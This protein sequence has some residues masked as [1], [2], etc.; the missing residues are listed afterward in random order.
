MN[1][2][3]EIEKKFENVIAS[4]NDLKKQF[5][6]FNFDSHD[7]TKPW[8]R[9]FHKLETI[10]NEVEIHNCFS[11]YGFNHLKL[12]E[13]FSFESKRNSENLSYQTGVIRTNCLECLDRTNMVQYIFSN[14]MI[15]IMMKHILNKE[16]DTPS[17][18]TFNPNK[19][20]EESLRVIWAE[21]GD[22]LSLAYCSGKSLFS[23][24]IRNNRRSL[25]GMILDIKNGLTRYI[26]NNFFD[27]YN[28]DCHDLFLC[29]LAPKRSI[30]E[31][32]SKLGIL[33]CMLFIGITI[34]LVKLYVLKEVE[35][36]TNLNFLV[37]SLVYTIC[38]F[39]SIIVLSHFSS[40][41]VD[42]PSL[43]GNTNY[44]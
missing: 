19:E 10:F 6:F 41:V 32:H 22:Q 14:K 37:T 44:F 23:D 20:I 2:K 34:L 36:Y 39:M 18:N 9:N 26:N 31:E 24:V 38:L 8:L 11:N 42:S 43:K 13:N 29:K 17:T 4:S 27:G 25:I 15:S 5:N 33:F 35:N 7:K 1:K 16:F 30:F 21:N 40:Y 12:S 3:E 28:Q